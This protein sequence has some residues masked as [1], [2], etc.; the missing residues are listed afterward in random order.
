MHK[1]GVTAWPNKTNY[2]IE[3]S[4]GEV[5]DLY[6]MTPDEA[7]DLLKCIKDVLTG[8]S[9]EHDTAHR[10]ELKQGN[11][12]TLL[13]PMSD[14]FTKAYTVSKRKLVELKIGLMGALN[15]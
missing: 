10:I 12:F 11:M 1:F 5:A 15:G 14:R 13:L 3:I 2:T 7:L 9:C 4:N 6:K 8:S